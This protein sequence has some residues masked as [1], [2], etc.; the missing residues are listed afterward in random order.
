M[1]VKCPKCGFD[2][3]KDTYCANCGIEM[4]SFKPK[5]PP[6]L[7]QVIKSPLFSLFLFIAL[8]YG[9]FLYL[10]NPSE[11]EKSLLHSLGIKK[12]TLSSPHTSPPLTPSQTPKPPNPPP[13]PAAPAPRGDKIVAA[14]P[15]PQEILT[16]AETASTQASTPAP[17]DAPPKPDPTPAPTPSSQ[18]DSTDSRSNLMDRNTLDSIKGPLVVEIR[19]IE[20]PLHLIQNFLS[21]AADNAGGDTG[22]MSYAIVKNAAPWLNQSAFKELD[23]LLKKVPDVKKRL[24][25]FSGAHDPETGSPIGLDFQISIQERVGGH[26]I[27]D[28]FISRSIADHTSTGVTTQRKEFTTHFETDVGSLIGLSGVMPRIELKNDESV[29]QDSLLKIFMS[30]NFIKGESDLLILLQ[31]KPK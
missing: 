14:P 22:D 29:F 19:F 30:P 1:I 21:E 15:N 18:T 5:K 2:Q 6:I 28:L 4:E 10:K 11:F 8:G 27:G 17:G 12:K 16:A 25:W 31:F 13:P 23:R 7:K 3:P 24:Q 9:S 20:A 26:L